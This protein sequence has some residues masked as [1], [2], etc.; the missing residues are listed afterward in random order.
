MFKVLNT[1]PKIQCSLKLD[2]LDR[3]IFCLHNSQ[4]KNGHVLKEPKSII[5]FKQINMHTYDPDPEWCSQVNITT[6]HPPPPSA[7][8]DQGQDKEFMP[9]HFSTTFNYEVW[10][11]S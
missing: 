4:D 8:Y 10:T 1:R 3:N 2:Y 7:Q 11:I 9:T 6:L 5:V